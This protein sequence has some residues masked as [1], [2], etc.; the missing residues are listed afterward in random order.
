MSSSSSALLGVSEVRSA[1]AVRS[2]RQLTAAANSAVLARN[3]LSFFDSIATG[4]GAKPEQL[5]EE[6]C[7]DVV[8]AVVGGYNGCIILHGTSPSGEFALGNAREPGLA[9]FGLAELFDSIC[10]GPAGDFLVS[11]EFLEIIGGTSR[12]KRFD[13]CA[14]QRMA[15]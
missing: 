5:Y 4:K 2:R 7:A 12:G 3:E 11:M 13:E 6:L 8:R 9:A 15:L 1:V 14:M 10:R